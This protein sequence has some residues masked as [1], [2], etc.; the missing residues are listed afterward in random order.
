M[1]ISAEAVAQSCFVNKVFLEISQNSQEN[2]CA[3]ES[4]LI[5]LQASGSDMLAL[6]TEFQFQGTDTFCSLVLESRLLKFIFKA[7]CYL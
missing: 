7:V 2:T 3:R 4:F 6:F 1:Y 5:K